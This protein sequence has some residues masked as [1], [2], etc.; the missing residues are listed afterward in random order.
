M[1]SNRC[2]GCGTDHL[3]TKPYRR[4]SFT[5]PEN[6]FEIKATTVFLCEDCFKTSKR[7][8]LAGL[9]R[10]KQAQELLDGAE[11]QTAAKEE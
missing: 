10:F 8:G 3:T 2:D 9:R 1:K 11:D 4:D 7:E 6:N 5:G